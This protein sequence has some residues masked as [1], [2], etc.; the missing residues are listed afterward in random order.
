MSAIALAVMDDCVLF[1]GDGVATDPATGFVVGYMS[2]IT[3]MPD[4]NA[5]IAITGVGGFDHLL[6][7]YMPPHVRTFDDLLNVLPDLVKH[8][9]ENGVSNGL[10]RGGDFRTNVCVG[11][12]SD[13]R[14]KFEAWRVVSYPKEAMDRKTG[15]KTILEP[16]VL[17]QMPD[18][19]TWCSTSQSEEVN[20]KF[21]LGKP[22]EDDNAVD[23][24]TR[25]ICAS[26]A[27]SG[28]VEG[29]DGTFNAG[30]YIQFAQVQ[31]GYAQSWI[32]HRWPEDEIGRAID[33]S[34][35]LPMPK[36]LMDRDAA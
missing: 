3:V 6:G 28:T 27:G 1:A 11:G 10:F 19:A 34:L 8:C 36:Y 35:G 23:T 33:P 4:L 2:K 30:G 14:Q 31:R 21:R 18:G 15:E 16:W 17:H 12:W 5:V 26:R 20:A 9:H 24:L 13:E 7:W 32:A 29:L 25:I 22:H